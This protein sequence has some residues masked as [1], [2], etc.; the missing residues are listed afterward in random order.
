MAESQCVDK[1]IRPRRQ[2]HYI[3]E[4]S[5]T[6]V[7]NIIREILLG[8]ISAIVGQG[9][10]SYTKVSCIRSQYVWLIYYD[11]LQG[12]QTIVS[13]VGLWASLNC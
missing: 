11:I 2:I 5:Q 4:P 10:G 9:K 8:W 6:I 3:F 1:L 7:R 13:L 12:T